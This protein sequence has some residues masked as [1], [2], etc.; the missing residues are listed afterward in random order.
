MIEPEE[1]R[2]GRPTSRWRHWDDIINGIQVVARAVSPD[3]KHKGSRL[4]KLAKLSKPHLPHAP[5]L[6]DATRRRVGILA[7]RRQTNGHGERQPEHPSQDAFSAKHIF[8]RTSEFREGSLE[9]SHLNWAALD[10][11]S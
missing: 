5:G 4:A 9:V 11:K 6:L 10:N 3:S 2:V 8:P 7:R 1:Q